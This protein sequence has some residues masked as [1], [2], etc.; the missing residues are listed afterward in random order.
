MG[1]KCIF[2]VFRTLLKK[3]SVHCPFLPPVSSHFYFM[4]IK[5]AGKISL[6]ETPSKVQKFENFRVK[7]MS[8]LLSTGRGF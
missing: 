4:V 8:T 3:F 5:L 1:E 2:E 6:K 7:T